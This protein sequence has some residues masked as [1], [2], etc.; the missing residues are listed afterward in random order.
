MPTPPSP[1]S[2]AF[3][4]HT[5]MKRVTIVD[6]D[7]DIYD[8]RDVEWAVATRFQADKGLVVLHGARG[9]SLDPS[10]GETTSKLGVDATMPVGGGHGFERAKL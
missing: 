10:A 5:S 7:I 4:S 8:D 9:S 6:E 1:T 3:G 2:A